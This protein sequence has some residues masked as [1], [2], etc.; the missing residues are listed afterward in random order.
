MKQSSIVVLDIGGTK[1]HAGRYRAGKIEQNFRLPFN[2]RMNV[3][4]IINFIIN[5]INKLKLN[6]TTAIAI[7][8]PSIV[9]IEQGIIF[10]AINIDSWQ[11]VFLKDELQSCFDI[12]VYINNDVNCF[13]KGEHSLV[14]DQGY[15]DM[16]GLCL[17]TGFGAGIILQNNLYTGSNCCAGELGSVPYL[18]SSFDDYCSGTFFKNNYNDCGSKLAERART[19]DEQGI[20]AFEQFGCHLSV[21]IKNILLIF[22][23]Q[24]IVLGG[25]VAQSYDLF[26]ESVW[27]HLLD[28]PYQNVIENLV[29]E[30]SNQ[31]NSALIG[32]AQLYLTSVE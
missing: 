5:C 10:D 14:A 22:D 16:V 1:I 24:L 25:S 32:T 26:I 9:D 2:A 11:K 12:P 31:P 3:N 4:D 7:G 21:A 15:S 13:T 28:F 27:R 17:G 18:N 23:P 29:I 20:A 19:G 6:D 8:V 30:K